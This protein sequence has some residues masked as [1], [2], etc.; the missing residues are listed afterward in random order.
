MASGVSIVLSSLGRPRD[1]EP[2]SLLGLIVSELAFLGTPSTELEKLTTYSL[3][4]KNLESFIIEC[5]KSLR[6]SIIRLYSSGG[7]RVK[8]VLVSV[9]PV[10]LRL[11]GFW[12]LAARSLWFLTACLFMLLVNFSFLYTESS[13]PVNFCEYSLLPI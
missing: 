2:M 10:I 11:S 6:V 9:L 13:K 3:V 8:L 12:Y 5:C 7:M 4:P 1:A